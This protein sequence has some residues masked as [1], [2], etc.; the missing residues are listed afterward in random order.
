MDKKFLSR[1]VY[2]ELFIMRCMLL[3]LT[4]FL[5]DD[6]ACKEVGYAYH[7]RYQWESGGKMDCDTI[8]VG[9][10]DIER[11][12]LRFD[13]TYDKNPEFK[14]HRIYLNIKGERFMV[15]TRRFIDKF[16][17]CNLKYDYDMQCI[18]K[19]TKHDLQIFSIPFSNPTYISIEDHYKPSEVIKEM[20]VEIPNIPNSHMSLYPYVWVET[21]AFEP[22][23]LKALSKENLLWTQ[24]FI[25]G[26]MMGVNNISTISWLNSL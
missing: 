14:H 20:L 8:V 15:Y 26:I 11:E 1:H 16:F 4:E 13:I 12:K 23:H 2:S 7:R 6:K 5:E 25:K 10:E 18:Y 9:Y 19:G 21:R 17:S 24:K 3:Q 22:S